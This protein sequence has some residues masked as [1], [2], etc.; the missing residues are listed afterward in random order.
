MM[1]C[2]KKA[3]INNRTSIAHFVI[4]KALQLNVYKPSTSYTS[5][6]LLPP[7]LQP[8]TW[9]FGFHPSP[10]RRKMH[11]N[12]RGKRRETHGMFFSQSHQDT[13][14]PDHRASGRGHWI[15][16]TAVGSY[17]HSCRREY[18]GTIE[19]TGCSWGK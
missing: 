1:F 2:T 12:L 19:T 5:L 10:A 11:R 16:E 15:L 8:P 18:L 9:N 6:T 7:N 14:A 17:L 13:N 4:L 3:S